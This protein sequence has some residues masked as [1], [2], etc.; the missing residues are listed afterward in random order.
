[1]D[2]KSSGWAYAFW[3][4]GLVGFCGIHRFYVGKWG[5]G[6]LWL[7]TGGLLLIGQFIDLILIPRMVDKENRRRAQEPVF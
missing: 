4:L 7:L 2:F 3:C 5:T 1:M 6:I